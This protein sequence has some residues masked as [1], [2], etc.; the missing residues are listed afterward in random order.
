LPRYST[1]SKVVRTGASAQNAAD[2]KP[3]P[4]REKTWYETSLDGPGT[5]TAA[6]K[7]TNDAD[8]VTNHVKWR[9]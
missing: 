8:E 9:G 7:M 4:P 6:Q 5:G 1:C 3:V 2:V